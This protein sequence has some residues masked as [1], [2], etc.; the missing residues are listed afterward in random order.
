MWPLAAMTVSMIALAGCQADDPTEASNS[1]AHRLPE[2]QASRSHCGAGWSHAEAGPVQVRVR[3]TDVNAAEVY[4]ADRAGRLYGEIDPLAPGASAVLRSTLSAGTYHLV[5]SVNDG[6][7]VHGP[8]VSVTGAAKGVRGVLP[9]T[10]ADLAPRVI[11][12][13]GWIKGKLKVLQAQ[14][15]SLSTALR[16]GDRADARAAW[17]KANRTWNTMGGAYGAFGDLGDAIAGNSLGLAGGTHDKHWTGLLRIEYGLWHGQSTGSLG[18]FGKK[19]ERD[20][21]ALGKQLETTQFEPIDIVRRAHE[22]T[23]D[24][25]RET[26]TGHNDYGAHVELDEALAQLDGTTAVLKFLHPLLAPR[27]PGLPSVNRWIAKSRKDIRSQH[28]RTPAASGTRNADQQRVDADLSQLAELLTP[29]PTI[30][31]P[32]VTQ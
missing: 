24:T 2:A 9:V 15:R 11:A 29:V 1:G 26:L 23:E 21:G 31:E 6:S 20:V 16:S 3:N 13:Q 8:K 4:L 7:P 19:L 10:S 22:I 25:L 12:Y 14:T 28:G 32:R 30:L 18:A 17:K 5:C 27:Y